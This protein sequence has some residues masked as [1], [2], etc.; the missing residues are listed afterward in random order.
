MPQAECPYCFSEIDLPHEFADR[1]FRCPACDGEIEMSLS[2]QARAVGGRHFG[3]S[4]PQSGMV[5]QVKVVAILMIVQGALECL[6]G[7]M[8]GGG[9]TLAAVVE[10]QDAPP[11]AIFVAVGLFI[12]AIGGTRIFAGIRNLKFRGRILGIVANCLGLVT[13]CTMYCAPTSLGLAVYAL[14]VYLNQDVEDAFSRSETTSA[15]ADDASAL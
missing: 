14:I 6:L 3:A 1:S 10:P 13:A 9:M 4:R 12:V 2:G 7:L 8:F 11:V 5:Q 15:S